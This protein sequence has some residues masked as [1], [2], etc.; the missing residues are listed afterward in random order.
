MTWRMD[1]GVTMMMKQREMAD[2]LLTMLLRVSAST[3]ICKGLFSMTRTGRAEKSASLF[4]IL[5]FC[6]W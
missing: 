6:E 3:P 4:F 2:R 1:Q 5:S